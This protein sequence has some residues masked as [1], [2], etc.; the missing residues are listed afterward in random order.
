MKVLLSWLRDFAPLEG[1]P[2]ELAADLSDLGL[3]VEELVHFQGSLPGVVVGRV[4]AK[5][6][7]PRAERIGLVEVERSP[8]EVVQVCCGAFNM[9]VGD[10]VPLAT[11]GAKLPNGQEIGLR[12]MRGESSEG[13]LCS[14]AELDMG[15]D[16]SGILILPSDLSVGEELA[17]ALSLSDDVILDLEVTPNRPD[18]LSMAGVARDLAARRGVPFAIPEPQVS[19]QGSPV[20]AAVEIVAADLCGRFCVMLLRGVQDAVCQPLL[21]HRLLLAGMRPVSAM[22]DISNYVMLE[23]GQPS[24]AFDADAL[25]GGA[26]SVRRALEGEKLVTLDGSERVLSAGDG[27]IT[28][29]DDEPVSIAGVMGGASTEVSAE[30]QSILLEAAWW[31][32]SDIAATSRRMGLRSEASARFEAGVDPEITE[33]ALSRFAELAACSGV[34]AAPGIVEAR[35][36]LPVPARLRLRT[37]RL[38]SILGTQLSSDDVRRCLEPI[39]FSLKAVQADLAGDEMAGASG[40]PVDIKPLGAGA[41][42]AVGAQTG[43]ETVAEV[44]A[45]TAE[46]DFEVLVPS[47]R[48]DTSLEIDLIE[49]VGRLWGF[50]RI[51]RSVPKSPSGGGLSRRQ[52]LRRRVLSLLSG[53]GYMQAM[54]LPF[55]APGDLERCGLASDGLTLT[56]PLVAEESVLRTSLRPGLLKAVRYN[57]DRRKQ[58]VRLF[59]V[60]RVWSSA[61]SLNDDVSP[62][63]A[64]ATPPASAGDTAPA[65]AGIHHFPEETEHL[66]VIHAG[67]EAPTAVAVWRSLQ[68][69]MPFAE[70]DLV[71]TP[72]DGLHSTRSAVLLAE[73][74]LLGALG[75]ID[76]GVLEACGIE[77]RVAWFECNLEILLGRYVAEN[78]YFSPSRY[79][80]SDFDLAFILADEVAASE[81]EAAL[82]SAA[83]DLLADLHLFDVFRSEKLGSDRRSLAWRLRLQAAD[84]TLTDA[85]VAEARN[86]A[87]E[88]AQILGAEL[89][90]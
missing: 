6:P 24:H 5:R 35:G 68:R 47:W 22:V 43:A 26:F 85:E 17:S 34:V 67:A 52:R 31:N 66:A 15:A 74:K 86:S 71:N 82:R 30:T 63:S 9:S 14:P 84:H 88:A 7:H 55:L 51:P 23:L 58:G 20:A 72:V 62:P 19:L 16:D 1:R 90:S 12:K 77:E 75:E 28:N 78:P 60:G 54:P 73:G 10:L 87:I 29:A 37:A 61:S 11:V 39:G 80:S 4:L 8:G 89:R 50:G 18:A 45:E 38:N 57:A 13:M 32:P 27:I 64:E 41:A 44:S 79:P 33:F 65:S 2:E 3:A 48:P 36:D 49:E 40:A 46:I 21:A 76:P 69:A 56:N 59:E 25:P 83:G 70:C 53:M 81:L 42:G